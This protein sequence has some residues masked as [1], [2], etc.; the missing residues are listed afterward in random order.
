[1]IQTHIKKIVSIKKRELAIKELQKFEADI[2]SI[3]NNL[4]IKEMIVM[5]DFKTILG[6][7]MKNNNF[8]VDACFMKRSEIKSQFSLEAESQTYPDHFKYSF[9]L[10]KHMCLLK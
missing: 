5:A 10:L 9:I 3:D 6:I 2:H 7:I 4:K 1:M 8:S